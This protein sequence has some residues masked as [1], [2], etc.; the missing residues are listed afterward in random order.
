[1]LMK[2]TAWTKLVNERRGGLG[3]DAEESVNRKGKEMEETP[4]LDRQ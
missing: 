3:C 1:M 2:S 4:D